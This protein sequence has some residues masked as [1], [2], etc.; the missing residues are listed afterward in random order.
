MQVC[1]VIR[2]KYV[3]KS[4]PSARKE[5]ERGRGEGAGEKSRQ[6]RIKQDFVAAENREKKREGKNRTLRTHPA[7]RLMGS[8]GHR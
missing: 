2:G 8:Y 4:L 3:H 1:C 6:R 5:K 7:R